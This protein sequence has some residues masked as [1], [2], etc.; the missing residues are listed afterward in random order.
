M[1]RDIDVNTEITIDYGL[2]EDPKIR[3]NILFLFTAVHNIYEYIY[4][5]F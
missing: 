4:I 2:I 3:K 1:P 5:Y